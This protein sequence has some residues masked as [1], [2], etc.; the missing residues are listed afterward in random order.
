MKAILDTLLERHDAWEEAYSL[1]E[2]D[3]SIDL[4]RTKGPQLV[5]D[6]YEPVREK[7]SLEPFKLTQRR[8]SYTDRTNHT[9][10]R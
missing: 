3:A 8:R 7:I 9:S 1:A 2:Q 5:A 6:V 10:C 4:N